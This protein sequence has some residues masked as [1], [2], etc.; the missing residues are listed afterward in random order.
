[1]TA[2]VPAGRVFGL[3][4]QTL[5]SIAIHLFNLIVLAFFVSK[6]LYKPVRNF[7]ANRTARIAEQL[8]NA[9]DEMAI[10][11]R[12]KL[13]YEAKLR[14]IEQERDE[15]F[16]QAMKNAADER[17]L[18][19]AKAKEDAEAIKQKAREDAEEIRTEAREGLK[20]FVLD[21]STAMAARIVT[22]TIDLETQDALFNQTLNDMEG[23]SWW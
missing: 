20:K 7:L 15:L 6:L 18:I 17:S 4:M 13:E 11:E 14:T 19:L 23:S 16:A 12:F 2:A 10:G 21:A 22:H 8:R 9:G 5:I 1:M 3:D